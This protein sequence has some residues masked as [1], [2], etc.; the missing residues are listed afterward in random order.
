MKNNAV[1]IT[2]FLLLSKLCIGIAHAEQP[3]WKWI[4]VDPP[5]TL[6]TLISKGGALASVFAGRGSRYIPD[7]SP[8]ND[9]TFGAFFVVLE[10]KL[11]RCFTKNGKASDNGN[12]FVAV[13]TRPN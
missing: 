8:N 4:S 10:G 13:D 12:C 5:T 2:I 1:T 6:P 11:Y 3:S 9:F 7:I